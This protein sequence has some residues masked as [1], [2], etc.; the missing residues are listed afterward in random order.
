MPE[1]RR[2]VPAQP[3]GVVAR[4]RRCVTITFCSVPKPFVGH[5]G[6]I[7]RNALASWSRLGGVIVFGDEP[8]VAEAAPDAGVRH[9]PDVAQNDY[10]TPLLSDAF[11][12]AEELSD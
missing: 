11:R 3:R 10:G 5:I 2:L 4:G 7:Q 8:G 9:V 6:V 1:A 12:R